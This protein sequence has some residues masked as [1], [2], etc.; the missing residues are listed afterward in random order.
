MQQ[1][2]R[3]KDSGV[4]REPG[5]PLGRDESRQLFLDTIMAAR[6]YLYI[7][8]VGRDI[9]DRKEKPPSV[10]V[11][12]LKTYL[13]RE[14]GENSFIELKEPI[15][16]FSPELF[17]NGAA[18]QSFS[19]SMRD[20]AR[21]IAA[22]SNA[23][24]SG[25]K[26]AF[27]IR[28]GIHSD[29]SAQADALCRSMDFDDLIRF[30]VNPSEQYVR[31]TLDA[32]LSVQESSSPEDSEPFENRLDYDVKD[33]LF[34][35]YLEAADRDALKSV[36][37]RR[38][39]CDG[40]TPLMQNA[41]DWQDWSDIAML[42]QG[43]ESNAAGL[44]EQ[45]IPA[46]ETVLEY[47]AADAGSPAGLLWDTVP[48]GTFRTALLLPD[49][50]VYRPEDPGEPC[51]R[52]EWSFAKDVSG[53]QLIRPI[54]DHL[55]ANLARKTATRIVYLDRYRHIVVMKADAMEQADA[56]KL[57][58]RFLCFYHAGMRKPLPFFPKTSYAFFAEADERKKEPAAE[59]QW[60]GGRGG[61]GDV[62]KFGACFGTAFPMSDCFRSLSEA[63][64]GAVAFR[65]EN[66]SGKG[67]GKRK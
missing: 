34:R 5:D 59:R 53:S 41:D 13:T 32:R 49:M 50:K 11:D 48:D 33:E 29:E 9:H 21:Q 65:Q 46:G 66:P 44:A 40:S 12:E 60:L 20:A 45:T 38:L 54:L 47:T 36:S 58:K 37:L 3:K 55:R 62:E 16:A 63:F 35:S 28:E 14:F 64:F 24:A 27:D 2:R 22:Q 51:V 26:P 57:V 52:M 25:K 18:N 17:E 39:K 7:S 42:A 6:K 23:A 31:D 43:M 4:G 1:P 10:C 56:E 61:T 30:F 15:H 8:Y 67:R 19:K